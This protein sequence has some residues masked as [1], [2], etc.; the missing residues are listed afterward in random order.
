MFSL[1]VVLLLPLLLSSHVFSWQEHKRQFVMLIP[2]HLVAPKIAFIPLAQHLGK[3]GNEV[4]LVSLDGSN[5]EVQPSADYIEMKTYVD[6][7][8]GR[9]NDRLQR[10]MR[11]FDPV[12]DMRI[13]LQILCE[14]FINDPDLKRVWNMEPDLVLL[15]SYMN[16]CGL[17]FVE[18]FKVPFVYMTTSGLLL[19]NSF[20]QYPYRLSIENNNIF[21]R[22]SNFVA[23][24]LFSIGHQ[25]SRLS[26]VNM[27]ARRFFKNDSISVDHLLHNSSLILLNSHKYLN[28]DRP[29]YS[30]MKNV[31]EVGCMQ[32]R[33]SV[34][35][36]I[37]GKDLRQFLDEAGNNNAVFFSLGT[38]TNST[39][40]AAEVLPV[41]L[42]AFDELP[43]QIV[44][45]YEGELKSPLHLPS[46]VF[47]SKWLY[48]QEV[49]AHPSV[50]AFFTHASTMSFHEAVY[51]AVPMIAL[52]FTHEQHQNALTI[53]S[54]GIGSVIHLNEH[55]SEDTIVPIVKDVMSDSIKRR[56]V[57]SAS[58]RFKAR[59]MDAVQSAAQG[60]AYVVEHNGAANLQ[61]KVVTWYLYLALNL[62]YILLILFGV[63]MSLVIYFKFIGRLPMRFS[64]S[65][66]KHQVKT[67]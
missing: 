9:E 36:D 46:N 32:C 11:Q 42:K 49:L 67:K 59:P 24:F 44:W 5:Y 4:S 23:N 41:L 39:L 22:I 62:A 26:D 61:P 20:Y 40:M 8:I 50:G 58:R 34:G 45:K 66:R 64:L 30:Q 29:D 15:P 2:N 52:P 53:D 47:I 33:P 3:L 57:L 14:L 17:I 51:H 10:A 31:V 54:L 12:Q 13:D 21:T 43:F 35:S 38:V 1:G 37:L 63:V 65:W 28:N 19:E 60:L 55:L 6:I 27:I 18:K 56:K 16:E 7:V 25:Q 48:Q